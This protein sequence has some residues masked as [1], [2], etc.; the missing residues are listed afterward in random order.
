M[1][2]ARRAQGQEPVVLPRESSYIGTLLDDLVTKD[3]REPYRMLTSRWAT[4][5]AGRCGAGLGGA[6][7]GVPRA[8]CRMLTSRWAPTWASCC[9]PPQGSTVH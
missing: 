4:A 3:L 2:A 8:G 5:W 7:A 9:V 1:N 6:G